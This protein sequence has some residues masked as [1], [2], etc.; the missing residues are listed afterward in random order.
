MYNKQKRSNLSFRCRS[1]TPAFSLLE[2]VIVIVVI[3]ILSTTIN[4]SLNTNPLQK[5]VNQIISH[6]R[7][8][9]HLA[10]VDNKY[11]PN[12]NISNETTPLK[13]G[14]EV[15]HWYRGRWQLRFSQNDGT[16]RYVVFSDTPTT[17]AIHVEEYDGDP[18]VAEIAINPLDNTKLLIAT[19]DL[20][21]GDS[22]I[23][24]EL[25]LFAKY[26]I[27]GVDFTGGCSN[28]GG[29]RISFDMFGRPYEGPYSSNTTP[30]DNL[31]HVPCVITLTHS[32]GGSASITI[33]PFTGRVFQN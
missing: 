26:N 28:A 11:M 32:T 16:F 23:T 24:D 27:T 2:I 22:R 15:Q 8:T 6:I 1:L 5:A 9:Q 3:G 30:Y 18:N 21:I 33:E 29:R 19:N 10:L 17:S 4:F 25:N 14:K 31:L 13:K 20:G 12:T 7:Y